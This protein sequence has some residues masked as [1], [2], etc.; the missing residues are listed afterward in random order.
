V[1]S[2]YDNLKTLYGLHNYSPDRIWNYDESRAQ[3]GKNGGGVVIVRTGARRVHS[4]V[5]N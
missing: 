1:K 5:P 3:V 4:I 2:F